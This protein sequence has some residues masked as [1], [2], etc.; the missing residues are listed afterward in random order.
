M[1]ETS[2][3]LFFTC[4]P[5]DTNIIVDRPIYNQIIQQYTKLSYQF[6]VSLIIANICV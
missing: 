5:Y 6:F 1:F 4:R 2:E 3:K